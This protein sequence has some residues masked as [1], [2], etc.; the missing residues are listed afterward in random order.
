MLERLAI[1]TP[2]SVLI[3]DW[4][5][6]TISG[7][8]LCAFVRRTYDAARLP[9]LMVTA[10]TDRSNLLQAFG[11]GANDYIRKPFDADELRARIATTVH[12]RGLHRELAEAREG[13]R[14]EA[15]LR[16]R[17]VGILGHDL[18]QPLNAM[19]V[20]ARTL[21]MEP[22]TERQ[23]KTVDRLGVAGNR[24]LRMIA[25]ILDMTR[26]RLGEGLPLDPEEADVHAIVESAVDSVRAQDP[27]RSFP[28]DLSGN[29][30][31]R[32][33]RDRLTQVCIN[34]LGNAVEHGAPGSPIAVDVRDDGD[35]A[36]ALR[37][38]NAGPDIPPEKLTTLFD[39]FRRGQSQSSSHGL[40]LG[41]FI[42]RSIVEGHGGHVSVTSQGGKTSFTV[43]LP[44]RPV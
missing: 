23:S 2:P 34:L 37:I 32:W 4:M 13:L 5:V 25:D 9:I 36:V 41:L 30:A 26:A 1:G 10:M 18:R 22:L 12:T 39:P 20:G 6:P 3:L 21:A 28:V 8:E 29:G 14:V 43:R 42:V 19:L 27:T 44:R 17:F 11:A 33:D 15:E 38:S 35:D 7:V 40:G 16:E 24:M 31:G